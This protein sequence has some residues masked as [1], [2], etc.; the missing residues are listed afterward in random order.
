MAARI[1]PLPPPAWL[2]EQRIRNGART[3]REIDPEFA[4]WCDDESKLRRFQVA[5]LVVGS[6][7]IA[8]ILAVVVAA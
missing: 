7:G 6:I 4:K 1:P 2:V 5:C 8:F 3:M